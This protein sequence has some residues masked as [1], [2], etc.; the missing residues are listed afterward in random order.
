MKN[1]ELKICNVEIL[2]SQ[3][4]TQII[5]GDL[6][7]W[8]DVEGV[9][10]NGSKAVRNFVYFQVGMY[11]LENWSDIKSGAVSAWEDANK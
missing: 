7:T 9:L 3:N 1:L 4:L 11:V 8:S 10:K 6:P 2:D 5:G